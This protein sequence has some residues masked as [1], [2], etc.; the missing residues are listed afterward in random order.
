MLNLDGFPF[1]RTFN[2]SSSGDVEQRLPGNSK[3]FTK[4]TCPRV[5]WMVNLQSH[6]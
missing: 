3:L 5:K 4:G 1:L 6:P 2:V